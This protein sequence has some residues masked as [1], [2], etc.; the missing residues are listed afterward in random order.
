MENNSQT[1]VVIEKVIPKYYAQECPVC[2]GFGTLK[3]GAKT[4]QGCEGRG[5][6]FVPTGTDGG[7]ENGT[8][9]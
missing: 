3:Y 6:I 8:N 2:H 7:K 9:R 1:K 4:C 5:Y